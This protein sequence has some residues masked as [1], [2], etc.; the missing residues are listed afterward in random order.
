MDES[1]YAGGGSTFAMPNPI[2][3]LSG[4]NGVNTGV[5]E[6]AVVWV[7]ALAGGASR[8]TAGNIGFANPSLPSLRATRLV[9]GD[10]RHARIATGPTDAIQLTVHSTASGAVRA[11]LRRSGT[12]IVHVLSASGRAGKVQFDGTRFWIVWRDTGV[13]NLRIASIDPIGTL[14]VS[15]TP[16]PVVAGD[17]AF[18]LVRTSTT[19]TVLVALASDALQLVTLC[20]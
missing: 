17:D 12:D 7:E 11:T 1:G 18:D 13:A 4:D 3:E 6:S 5:N 9:S 2:T 20:R 19:T 14:V 16:G 10:C 8:C 15:P